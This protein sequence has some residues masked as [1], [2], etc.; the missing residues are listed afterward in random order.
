M[1]DTSMYGRI[2]GFDQ[3]L[4]MGQ[5]IGGVFTTARNTGLREQALERIKAGEDYNAVVQ[6]VMQQSPEIA[7][8]L[9]NLRAANMKAK[10]DQLGIQ[11]TE[12]QIK[13]GNENLSRA[14]LQQSAMPMLGALMVDNADARKKLLE[15]AAQPIKES[16][17]AVFET[18]I[19]IGNQPE[20]VQANAISGIIKTLRQAGVYPDDPTELA[21]V[22]AQQD[23]VQSS[24]DVEGGTLITYRSGRQ[25]FKPFG[26]DVYAASEQM[27][28]N[29][30]AKLNAAQET[31]LIK[32][33]QAAN[34]SYSLASRTQDLANQFSQL[35]VQ[36]GTPA[37]AREALLRVAGGEDGLSLLRRE[38]TRV[39]NALIVE[40]LPQG[41]ATDKDIQLIADGFLPASANPQAIADF[42]GAMSRAQ[43][44]S[45]M[46]NEFQANFMQ[47]GGSMVAARKDF[48]IDGFTVKKGERVRDAYKRYAKEVFGKQDEQRQPAQQPARR[49]FEAEY[50]GGGR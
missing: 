14:K 35:S 48:D 34:Q 40:G 39:R 38:Y 1:I 18:I 17:P 29:M 44:A 31:E 7:Q 6:E 5:A 25:E 24:R 46:F 41:P 47:N 49:N 2:G 21:A 12:Q 26:E 10:A 28:Q 15:E 27:R 13:I 4:R 42:L 3:G 30:P 11:Q 19:D 45:A 32:L 8:E 16:N 22:Q 33:Q 20:D 23:T 36:G 50:L 43:Q 9:I 37:Q